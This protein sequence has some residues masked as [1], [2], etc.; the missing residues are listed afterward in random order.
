MTR[1]TREELELMDIE[2]LDR[3]AFGVVDGEDVTIQPSQVRILYPCD[4]ENPQALFD[5]GGMAWARS[6]DLSEP[7]L[8]SVD[9]EG[10]FGLEDGHHRWFA[11][12][13]T[14]RDLVGTVTIKGNPVR[15]ILAR[16]EASAEAPA[17][18]AKRTP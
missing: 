9:D 3:M 1:Y 10:A 18:K 12:E 7:V 11:A 4:L 16:Q 13:K 2:E 15:R 8:L 6:V 17:R 5:K 14:G